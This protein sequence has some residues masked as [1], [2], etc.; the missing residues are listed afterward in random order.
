[1]RQIS[2]LGEENNKV[3]MITKRIDFYGIDFQKNGLPVDPKTVFKHIDSLNPRKGS[4]VSIYEKTMRD[5]LRMKPPAANG[6]FFLKKDRDIWSMK[7]DSPT[8][9][10]KARMGTI[11]KTGL[12]LLWKSGHVFPLT[13]GVDEGLYE[14]MHF[15]IFAEN[16]PRPYYVVG[17]EYNLYGPK[18]LNFVRYIERIA[19]PVVGKVELTVLMREDIQNLLNRIR[20]IRVLK[21][22]VYRDKGHLLRQLNKSL[23][24]AIAALQDT[25]DAECIEIVL[26]SRKN[27]TRRIRI[28]FADRLAKWLATPEAS[29]AV[30]DLKIRAKVEELRK[31]VEFDL[32][33][34]LIHSQTEVIVEV[35]A[36]DIRESG[37]AGT[38]YALSIAYELALA[39]AMYNAIE[40]IYRKERSDI[41]GII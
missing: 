36:S 13:A 28:P 11:R 41:N 29:E 31:T 18:P 23:P 37:G 25:T 2:V 35:K 30:D 27:S 22:R 4:S 34:P 1:M 9:P 32:L 14:P 40:R 26:R 38:R 17:F 7:I 12:P 24:D 15:M 5:L 39:E 16:A 3:S 33:K 6:R 21:L 19:S 8:I 10:I 20:E